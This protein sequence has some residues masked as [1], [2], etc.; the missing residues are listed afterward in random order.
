MTDTSSRVRAV[1]RVG[2]DASAP[3]GAATLTPR[4]R[5]GY[6]GPVHVLQLL[7]VEAVL[8]AVLAAAARSPLAAAG[9]AVVAV[10]LGAAALTR[11]QGRWWLERRVLTRRYRSR[12]RARPTGQQADPRLTALRWL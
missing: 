4:R 6:L 1:A 12:R 7:L 2:A 11:R 5:P 10:G 9:A 3:S 8:V